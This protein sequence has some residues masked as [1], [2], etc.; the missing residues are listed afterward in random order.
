L[1]WSLAGTPSDFAQRM[2][3]KAFAA[4]DPANQP[5]AGTLL[6]NARQ[7]GLTTGEFGPAMPEFL[8]ETLPRLT[9]IHL[10]GADADRRLGQIADTLS[11]DALWAKTAIFVV[12]E[13]SPVLVISPYSRRPAP[14]SGMFY[15]HSSVLRTMETILKLRSM[16]IFDASARPLTDV[17]SRTAEAR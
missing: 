11:K 9:V 12:G 1:Q 7:A 5:P 13:T 6:V 3:G 4:T 14:T 16:T 10:A 15:N 8:P 17:F 2:R